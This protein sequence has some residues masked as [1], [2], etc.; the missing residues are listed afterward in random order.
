MCAMT[1]VWSV[2]RLVYGTDNKACS[3]VWVSKACS[4][5]HWVGCAHG[6]KKKGRCERC[7]LQI[8]HHW[9]QVNNNLNM[10]NVWVF[11]FVGSHVCG[12]EIG[13]TTLLA[14]QKVSWKVTVIWIKWGTPK[15][16][17]RKWVEGVEEDEV[18]WESK[19]EVYDV[20]MGIQIGGKCPYCEQK[21]VYGKERRPCSHACSITC[22]STRCLWM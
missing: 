3:T 4:A 6:A 15:C 2:W 11:N 16:Y 22:R 19:D 7:T 5:V 14:T 13:Q 20:R 18:A 1:R 8:T 21:E 12:W 17:L 10:T 9:T